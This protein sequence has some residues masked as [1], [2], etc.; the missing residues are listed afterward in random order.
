M[1]KLSNELQFFRVLL[2]HNN[3]STN[4]IRD[5]ISQ[6]RNLLPIVL[7]SLKFGGFI[8]DDNQHHDTFKILNGNS[9]QDDI[10]TVVNA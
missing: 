8:D 4:L 7:D 2:M 1:S 10:M 6:I 5:K 9:L 3:H